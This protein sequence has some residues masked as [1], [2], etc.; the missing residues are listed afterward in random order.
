MLLK[1]NRPNCKA[2]Q[3]YYKK[4]NIGNFD[5]QKRNKADA[6]LIHQSIFYGGMVNHVS[7]GFTPKSADKSTK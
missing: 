5:R 4:W 2:L 7:S 1:S 6:T 3:R